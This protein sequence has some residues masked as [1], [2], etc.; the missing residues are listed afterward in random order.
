MIPNSKFKLVQKIIRAAWWVLVI[1]LALVLVRVIGAKMQGKVPSVFGY[2]FVHIISGSM[3][4]EIPRGSYIL[5]KNV[6][7]SEVGK[8]DIICFYSS[9]PQIYGLPNTHR[10]VEDPIV[11]DE[12]IEFVT[13][14]DANAGNDKYHAKGERL[15]GVYVKTMDTLTSFSELLSGKTMIFVIIG[16]QFGIFALVACGMARSVREKAQ[17][18]QENESEGTPKES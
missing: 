12:G 13:R 3:E 7:A 1:L 9:D 17:A 11:T 6:D 15:V 16:L 5:L 4:D 10:V 2:S 18:E 8:D 14:G